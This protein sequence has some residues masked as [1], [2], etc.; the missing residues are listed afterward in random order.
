MTISLTSLV[1]A[2]SATFTSQVARALG[3]D[4][5]SIEAI[6]GGRNSQVYHVVCNGAQEYVVKRYATRC[7]DDRDRLGVECSSLQFLWDHGVRN[8]P[9]PVISDTAE[10]WAVYVYLHG[11]RI[12]V[13]EIN[14]LDLED[15]VRFL[16]TLKSLRDHP[17]SHALPA[18]SEACFSTQAILD[19]LE[20]RLHRFTAVE[21]DD[22][23]FAALRT[24]FSS[25][26][27]PARERIV[28]WCSVRLKQHGSTFDAVLPMRYRTLSP[29]DFGFHNAL[30]LADGR[31]VYLDFEY[32]GWDDPAKILIDFVLHPAMALSQ[33]LGRQFATQLLYLFEDDRA[34]PQRAELFYPLFGLKW[35]L[36]LLNE[37][38]P[39]DLLRRGFAKAAALR[40]SELQMAQLE[41]AKRVLSR[42]MRDYEQFPYS[43]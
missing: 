40:T 41:K 5:A 42:V 27:Y 21:K 9:Q 4:I 20:Q 12:A 18:A 34:L 37:F 26:F 19:N 6:G 43:V 35:C 2:E 15:A 10:G 7:S 25:E 38:V 36:I 16:T 23:A 14:P 24:F 39:E 31:L 11:Q 17:D 30:R 8:I 28:R 3:A 32:F 13:S 29:S 1:D 33:P 22:A